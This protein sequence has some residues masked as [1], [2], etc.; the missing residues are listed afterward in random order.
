MKNEINSYW[1]E[2]I[3]HLKNKME[4]L[5]HTR[6]RKRRRQ[7]FS[8]SL[9]CIGWRRDFVDTD[10]WR[11][12]P[13]KDIL[14]APE[15]KKNLMLC[16]MYSSNSSS[17]NTEQFEWPRSSISPDSLSST[18][19]DPPPPRKWVEPKRKTKKQ[20]NAYKTFLSAQVS[21]DW[22]CI[23]IGRAFHPCPFILKSLN[24]TATFSLSSQLIR[25]VYILKIWEEKK[26]LC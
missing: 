2:G 3:R 20:K 19:L 13:N 24:S 22:S 11:H 17:S 21:A 14:F 4:S 7:L 10:T 8:L 26:N 25:I 1:L 5:D 6:I 9:N 18:W 16:P 15:Q 12:V 23:S